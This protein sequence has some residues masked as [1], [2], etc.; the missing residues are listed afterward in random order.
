MRSRFRRLTDLFVEGKALTMPD[1]TYIWVQVLNAFQRDECLSDAQVAK[2]RLVMAL[3]EQ[4]DEALKVRAR[5]LEKGAATLV[6]DLAASK[7]SAKVPEYLDELRDDPEWK[8]RMNI[9]LRSDADDV[10]TPLEE[11]EVLLLSK[12]NAEVLS[13]LQRRE[14]TEY[15]FLTRK[16]SQLP[17]DELIEVWVEN[18]LDKRGGDVANAEFKLTEMTYAARL[19]DAVTTEDGTLDHEACDGH[20]QPLFASRAEARECP[21]PLALLIQSALAEVNLVG[22][23]PKDSDSR[24]SSSASPPTPSEAEAS[25]AS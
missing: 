17:D 1:G 2:A 22:R 15:D 11:A 4:G 10:A 5:Y 20:S 6:K 19:C 16:Y 14:T 18:W 23:D 7:A 24:Q 9:V 8:E 25:T 21:T 3:K 13:E 12:I